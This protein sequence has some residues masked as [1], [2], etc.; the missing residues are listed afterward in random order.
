MDR[1]AFEARLYALVPGDRVRKDAA[2]AEFTTLRVGGRADYLVSP[3]TEEQARLALS[4]ARE[5]GVPVLILGNGS[6][7]LCRDG[8][9][10]GMTLRLGQD[11]SAMTRT[12]EGLTA[13]AGAALP[14][15]SRFAL[16]HG[17]TGLEFASGIPG[18]VGGAAAMNAGAYGGEMAQVV[19][20][21]R[22]L[23]QDGA[24]VELSG[25]SLRYRY[26]GSAVMDEGMLALSVDF[27]LQPGD[28]EQIAARM[29]ELAAARREKQ[30]LTFPSAGSFFKRP[31]GHFAGALIEQAGLKGT[32]VGGAQVSELHAGFLINTGGA[33]AKDFL[34]LMALVQREVYARFSVTLEPE[35]RIVGEDI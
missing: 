34:D 19:S 31:E 25:E 24:F 22:A 35:V 5:C 3:A 21:V 7:V 9:F 28:R 26:R 10:R 17:L 2:L 30:P 13:Q 8:G 14:A 16:S 18:T 29:A 4:A 20:R 11:F 12:D 32:R 15:V 1:S 23:T 33:T 27:A 6:N